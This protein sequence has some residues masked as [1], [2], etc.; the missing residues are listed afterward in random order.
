ML[1]IDISKQ[2]AKFLLKVHP[3]HGKQI[4]RKLMELRIN[5]TPTDS[6]KLKGFAYKRVDIG[7]Y[8]IVYYVKSEILYIVV[9]GKRNDDEVYWIKGAS[10]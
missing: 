10:K 7:E 9:V 8:R 6:I 2:A 1:K 5:P 3:K 4:A